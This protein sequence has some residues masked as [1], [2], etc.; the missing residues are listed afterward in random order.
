MKKKQSIESL[1]HLYIESVVRLHGVPK[2][3]ISD[4]D[5]RFTS[6]LWQRL[7]NAFGSQLKLSSAYHPHTDGQS[8]RTIRTLEDML[9]TCILEWKGD[10]ERQLS[11]VEFAYNNSFHASIGMAPYEALYGRPCRSPLC[12]KEVGDQQLIG[13]EVVQETSEK[14]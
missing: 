2:S 9:R 11:L 8:E 4:R 13:P 5:P 12:W 10:C 3:I 7:Q 1:A 14:I 6:R